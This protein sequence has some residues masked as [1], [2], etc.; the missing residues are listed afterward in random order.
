MTMNLKLKSGYNKMGKIFIKKLK[1]GSIF[2]KNKKMPLC[3]TA[4]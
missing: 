3:F 2:V 1:V 4:Q